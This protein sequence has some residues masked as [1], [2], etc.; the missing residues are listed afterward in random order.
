M[1]LA[2]YVW[3]FTWK[4]K[5]FSQTYPS[6]CKF[7]VQFVAFLTAFYIILVSCGWVTQKEGDPPPPQ[8]NSTL[9]WNLIS[10]PW[11][12][13]IDTLNWPQR[14]CN[15]ICKCILQRDKNCILFWF[16]LLIG[17]LTAGNGWFSGGCMG[18]WRIVWLS[19]WNAKMGLVYHMWRSPISLFVSVN[20]CGEM[21][22][23]FGRQVSCP[24]VL[25]SDSNVGLY[26]FYFYCFLTICIH[27]S[28]VRTPFLSRMSYFLGYQLI[29]GSLSVF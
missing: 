25:L 3:K 10:P 1:Q 22:E 28:I 14:A 2:C 5:S 24:S 21:E 8:Y 9:S 17:I 6:Q 12:S 27:V 18:A 19:N 4:Q 23:Q 13:E 7:S 15:Q 29:A 26:F 11:E 20:T 16:Y